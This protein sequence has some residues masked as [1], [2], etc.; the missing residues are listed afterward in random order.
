MAKQQKRKLPAGV[1]ETFVEEIQRLSVEQLKERIVQLQAAKEQ[2]VDGFKKSQGYLDA[3]ASWD[4]VNGPVR[5]TATAIKNKTKMILE[6]L[7]EQGAI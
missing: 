1:D 2:D 5:D 4:A 3:K 6:K 7:K